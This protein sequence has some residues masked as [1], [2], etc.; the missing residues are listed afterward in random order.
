MMQMMNIITIIQ[1]KM[2][3]TTIS[4]FDISLRGYWLLLAHWVANS[5]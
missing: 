3:M 2:T 1:P 5:Y 4:I